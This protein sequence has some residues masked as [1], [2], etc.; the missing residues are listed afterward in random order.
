MIMPIVGA[1]G[2]AGCAFTTALA[3]AEEVHPDE[4]V[5]VKV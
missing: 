4:L 5:T 3:E 1:E 2:V